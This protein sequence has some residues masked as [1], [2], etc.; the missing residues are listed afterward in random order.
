MQS[1]Q[2]NTRKDFDAPCHLIEPSFYVPNLKEDVR[3]GLLEAPY[4]LQPK[5][6]YDERGS[7]LF[8]SICNTPEY[9]PTRVEDELLQLYAD[10]IIAETLPKQIIEL[11]SGTSRKTR[12]LFDACESKAHCCS[13]APFDVCEPMLIQTAND[14]HSTYSWLDVS[15]LLGDY[16]AGLANLPLEY[17]RNL[18]VFLGSTIGN[19]EPEEAKSFILDLRNK[20]IDGD[21]FLIGA[22]RVKNINVLNAAYNDSRG[23]TAEF[24]LNV[25]RV[26]NRELGSNFDLNKFQHQAHYN[27][28]KGRIEMHLLSLEAQKID[29]DSLKASFNLQQGEKILTELSHKYEFDEIESLLTNSGFELVKHYQPDNQYFSLL[30]ARAV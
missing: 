2:K 4:S 25:L 6:F 1:L 11:G 30:L 23:L 19:F 15:P 17:N 20:M 26:L 24:N 7:Q 29:I 18:F 10:S 22:D 3:T 12:R 5:Y 16:H 8:D 21:F 13:Y 14:L 9:Y 27:I 28:E